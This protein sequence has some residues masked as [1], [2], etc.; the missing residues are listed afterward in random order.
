MLKRILFKMT[1]ITFTVIFGGKKIFLI[2]L[3]Q[4]P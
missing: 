2:G 1:V 3:I 4:D